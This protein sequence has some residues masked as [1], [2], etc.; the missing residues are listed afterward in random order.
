[1]SKYIKDIDLS[2]LEDIIDDE[3]MELIYE[4]IEESDK[5][6]ERKSPRKMRDYFDD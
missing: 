4:Q 6:R 2:Q 1:M 3:T 5:E